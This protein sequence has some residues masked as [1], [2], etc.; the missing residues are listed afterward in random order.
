MLTI[1][2]IGVGGAFASGWQLA[3]AAL[4]GITF[5]YWLSEFQILGWIPTLWFWCSVLSCLGSLLS[6]IFCSGHVAIKLHYHSWQTFHSFV[7]AVWL[8]SIWFSLVSG[9]HCLSTWAMAHCGR[10]LTQHILCLMRVNPTGGPIC[11]TLTTLSI[12]ANRLDVLFCDK[13]YP[14]L[15]RQLLCLQCFDAVGWVAGRA[16]GL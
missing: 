3:G 15:K 16:S 8:Q 4:W 7:F 14:V 2:L 12:P 6:L 9:R 11:S 10:T 13:V 1:Y 5:T